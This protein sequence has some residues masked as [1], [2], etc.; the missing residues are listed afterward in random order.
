MRGF[1]A[2]LDLPRDALR[3]VE[4]EEPE[5]MSAYSETTNISWGESVASATLGR[6]QS[7]GRIR[8]PG[9]TRQSSSKTQRSIETNK[10][11]LQMSPPLTPKRSQ[12]MEPETTFH[13]YLRAFYHFHPSSTV[14][15][16]TDESSIT[17]PINQGDVIL[18]HSIHPNGW[19]DGTLLVSGARGWLPTNYCEAYDPPFIRS[20]LNA[21]THLWDLVRS[22]ENDNLNVFTKQDYVR[23]M[24]AGVRYIVVSC[25]QFL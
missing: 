5:P 11:H 4:E 14:S 3:R 19:A 17:V 23:G 24:I 25:V 7:R 16:S 22:G 18:V 6:T 21:L 10:P 12:E 13:N 1:A 20:L 15:S 2:P 8:R 9:H